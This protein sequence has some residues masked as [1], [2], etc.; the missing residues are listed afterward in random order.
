M[1]L[2]RVLFEAQQKSPKGSEVTADQLAVATGS[3]KG[4][5]GEFFFP[6]FHGVMCILI[7]EI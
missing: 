4:L 1:G 7:E 5:V 6:K 3:E 2:F